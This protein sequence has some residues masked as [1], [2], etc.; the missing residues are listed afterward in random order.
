MQ[1][2]MLKNIKQRHKHCDSSTLTSH[3][4]KKNEP[5]FLSERFSGAK[6]VKIVEKNNK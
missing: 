6:E 2:L 4:N 1:T 3:H 5:S